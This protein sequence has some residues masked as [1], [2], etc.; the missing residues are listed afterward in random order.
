MSL[1]FFIVWTLC[2]QSRCTLRMIVTMIATVIVAGG[3]SNGGSIYLILSVLSLLSLQKYGT[4]NHFFPL[5]IFSSFNHVRQ[6]ICDRMR[7]VAQGQWLNGM[8][9][10]YGKRLIWQVGW[11]PQIIQTDGGCAKLLT[12]S[13][14]INYLKVPHGQKNKQKT[15]QSHSRISGSA[16]RKAKEENTSSKMRATPRNHDYCEED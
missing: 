7:A 6:F 12:S 16:D 5:L 9:T 10:N 14:N 13:S 4:M 8:F 11:H 2:V 1:L 3:G 15:K